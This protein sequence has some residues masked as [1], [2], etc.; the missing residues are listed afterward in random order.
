MDEH[1]AELL[2]RSSEIC[3][4]RWPRWLVLHVGL[5]LSLSPLNEP[6]TIT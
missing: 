3:F 6:A 4:F 5:L 1:S 2:V